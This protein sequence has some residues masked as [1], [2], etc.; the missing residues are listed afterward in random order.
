MAAT[1]FRVP[2]D[3]DE[4]VRTRPRASASAKPQF[5]GVDDYGFHNGAVWYRGHFTASG[6][7]RAFSFSGMSGR[8]GACA[9][10][11]NGAY[12]GSAT[13]ARDGTIATRPILPG[14]LRRGSRAVLSVLFETWDMT[15]CSTATSGALS[16]AECCG[17]RSRGR[18][19]RS[20]GTCSATASISNTDP[21]RG[22]LAAGG[23]R[24][25]DRRLA[26][27]LVRGTCVAGDDVARA[28]RREP[29]SLG[30]AGAW[31]RCRRWCDGGVRVTD[32]RR[33][34]DPLSRA[35]VRQRLADRALR[36]RCRCTAC[37]PD[38]R[39]LLRGR[40]LD[41]SRSPSGASTRT[42][43]SDASRSQPSTPSRQPTPR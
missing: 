19:R 41:T 21:V 29:A 4:G 39:G 10:W 27:S 24:G 42:A 28:P 6:R 31:H 36:R 14:A 37:L 22:P 8:G 30:I 20:I 40:A 33:A 32:R 16:R 34:A 18:R 7:E 25:R 11:L 9:V 2:L 35:A 13:A 17:P 12:L 43:G 23:S 26:G 3:L 5:L 1:Q 38:P 15:R